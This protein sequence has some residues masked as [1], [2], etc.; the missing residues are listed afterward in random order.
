MSLIGTV[1]SATA[2]LRP[3]N[4]L[5]GFSSG[6]QTYA[7][8]DAALIDSARRGAVEFAAL[9]DVE[10]IDRCD[11]LRQ[12]C[13]HPPREP[14]RLVHAAA[15]VIEATRRQYGIELYD[16]Q[17]RAGLVM[18]RGQ[19]AEMQTGEGKTFSGVLPTFLFAMAGRGVHVC[20]PNTYLATRDEEQLR[21]IF[22]RLGLA[23]SI[24]SE[25]DSFE[26]SCHAYQAD[27]T[28]AAGQQF[29]F[30]YLQ[31]QWTRRQFKMAEIG[32]T[33]T[34][35]L[36][37]RGVETRLRG[38]GLYAAVIDEADHVLV[39]DA[40][41]PLLISAAADRPAPDA[42]LHLAA[43]PIAL[44]LVP[45]VHFREEKTAGTIEL[46]DSGFQRVYEH[47]E[48][49]S[50]DR[51]CR[52]WHEYVLAALRAQR[53]LSRERHYVDSRR[54]I[55]A[56]GTE[57][58]PHLSRSNLVGRTS[59]SRTSERRP[60]DHGRNTISRKNYSASLFPFL[61]AP[62]WNDG[63]S[64]GMPTRTPIHLSIEGSNDSHTTSLPP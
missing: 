23:T 57:H 64:D 49:M 19:I 46:T 8:S 31:D 30:D 52:A 1:T 44:S 35:Q 63:H 48:Y 4:V 11:A 15:L 40:T 25:S 28:Y 42:E 45:D 60:R 53:T 14:E 20:T 54:R 18:S 16:V 7:D 5:A 17:L 62:V 21:P 3:W 58:W 36:L 56:G 43:R 9:S 38:R 29:G 61:S 2:G 33:T 34:Q 41:S 37:G 26:Q 59:P 6:R 10:L 51:L 22:R 32:T 13:I 39:D 24:R 55:A 50:H 27:I 47:D 12:R